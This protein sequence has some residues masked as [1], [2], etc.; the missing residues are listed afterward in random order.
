MAVCAV[1]VQV[2]EEWAIARVVGSP[3]SD[4]LAEGDLAELGLVD[5]TVVEAVTVKVLEGHGIEIVDI[6]IAVSGHR[7]VSRPRI[8]LSATPK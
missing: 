6:V 3:G 2:A 1:V 8:L 7:V 5:N 4:G